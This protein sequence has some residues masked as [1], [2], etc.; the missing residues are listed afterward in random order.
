[1]P[2][3][4]LKFGKLLLMKT[5]GLNPMVPIIIIFLAT[6]VVHA[7]DG[8]EKANTYNPGSTLLVGRV[9]DAEHF[10]KIL[11]NSGERLLVFDF[12]ADWCQPC[13]VLSPLLENLAEQFKDRTSFFKVD[14]DQNKELATSIGVR[15]VPYVLFAKNGQIVHTLLGVHPKDKYARLINRFSKATPSSAE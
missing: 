9:S 6:A 7:C 2:Y 8:S 4:Y 12:Y 1:L 10:R 15:G 11:N 5:N 3:P 13:Q 14:I